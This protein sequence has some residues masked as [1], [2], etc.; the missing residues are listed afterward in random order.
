MTE[1]IRPEFYEGQI[2]QAADLSTDVSYAR[3]QLAVHQR[4]LHSPG[5]AEGLRLVGSPIS[6]ALS[7]GASVPAISVVVTAGVFIDTAGRQVVV[8]EDV[9]LDHGLVIQAEPDPDAQPNNWS[10]FYPVFIEPDDIIQP[11]PPD[12]ASCRQGLSTRV[13]EGHRLTVGARA[14][15]LNLTLDLTPAGTPVEEARAGRLLLGFVRL[16]IGVTRFAEVADSLDGV[17]RTYVSV[18]ASA[19][20]GHDGKVELRPELQQKAGDLKLVVTQ[21]ELAFGPST[22]TG[23][24]T[25]LLRVTRAGNL[26]VTG[27]ITPKLLGPRFKSGRAPDGTVLPLPDGVSEQDVGPQGGFVWHAVVTP[28]YRP[29]GGT[30]PV[31]FGCFVD[32]TRTVRCLLTYGSGPGSSVQ[33]CEF[34]LIVLPKA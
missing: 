34:L 14:E 23:A 2:L 30:A 12:F 17:G 32:A 20:L 25:A 26:E 19:V 6:V 15:H 13:T 27:Q 8:P 11:A 33:E 1:V 16:D 4:F 5:I 22:A 10:Y 7:G 18:R 29:I 31:N 28:A 9:P 24:V 21:D 3:N